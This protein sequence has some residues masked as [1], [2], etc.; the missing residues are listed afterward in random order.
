MYI[1]INITNMIY[2]LK[3]TQ[4]DRNK[5]INIRAETF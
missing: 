2:V 5:D 1:L 3:Y 4:A